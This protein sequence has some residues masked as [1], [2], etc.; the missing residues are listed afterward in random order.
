MAANQNQNL[1]GH[2]VDTVVLDDEYTPPTPEERGDFIVDED[3]VE[4]DDLE[5]SDDDELEEESDEA[6]D[7]DGADDETDDLEEEQD[8]GDA[9]ASNDP[10]DDEDDGEEEKRPDPKKGN[11]NKRVPLNRLNKEIE[12]RRTLEGK[13]ADMQKQLEGLNQGSGK[14]EPKGEEAPSQAFTREDFEGMQEAMLD[15]ETDKAFELFGRMMNSQSDLVRKSTEEEVSGRVRSEIEQ[16]KAREELQTTA[17]TLAESYPELDS[18][19][20]DADQGLIEEVVEMRDIYVDR[21]LS[22]ADALKRS[23]KLVAL[24]NSLENRTAKPKADMA[25]PSGKRK[26][27]NTK[28]KLE[29]AKREKGKLSGSGQRNSGKRID[30]SNMAEDDFSKLSKEALAQARGDYL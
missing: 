25:A 11:G 15:G 19:S 27:V 5:I 17:A 30:I 20:D 16:D 21:G 28:A 13:L 23:V 1:N 3:D 12:K 10:N 29:A 7:E 24:E 2:D 26:N 8:E 6:D 22:L 9:E 14:G 18:A 4:V